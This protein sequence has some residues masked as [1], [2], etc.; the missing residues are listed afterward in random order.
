MCISYDDLE[1]VDMC[2]TQQLINLAGPCRASVPENINCSSITYR[3]IDNFDHEENTSSGIGGSHDTILVLFQKSDEIE[4]NE[5][6]SCKPEDI[7]AL[8]PCLSH[9]LDCQKLIKRAKFSN[10]ENIAADF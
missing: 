9:V 5:E 7:A 8:S 3:A 2:Q 10:R 6:I 1:R 4:I